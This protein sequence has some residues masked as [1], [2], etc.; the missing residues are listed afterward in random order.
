MLDASVEDLAWDGDSFSAQV[1]VLGN[2]YTFTATVDPETG[3]L[4]GLVTQSFG[5]K[6]T[7]PVTGRRAGG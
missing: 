2:L 7:A 4:N 1:T 3:E 5:D 6:E